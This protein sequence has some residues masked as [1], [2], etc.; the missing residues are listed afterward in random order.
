MKP[1]L[2]KRFL[3]M[4]DLQRQINGELLSMR[5]NCANQ[6]PGELRWSMVQVASHLYIAEEGSLRYMQK[7]IQAGDALSR[8]GVSGNIRKWVL[9]IAMNSRIKF[10]APEIIAHPDNE[11]SAPAMIEK[12]A[13]LRGE[14]KEFLESVPA[15]YYNRELFRHPLMGRMNIL[16]G[17]DFMASH[18]QRHLKQIRRIKSELQS[19]ELV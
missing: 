2:Q 11:L 5:E 19:P 13:A 12:W 14:L 17:V 6:P 9:D 8:S 16:Q 10:K 3:R 18:M 4:E 7:K 15:K 1:S